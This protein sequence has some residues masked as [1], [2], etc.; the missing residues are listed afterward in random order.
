MHSPSNSIWSVNI[1]LNK[2]HIKL[3]LFNLVIFINNEK[4]KLTTTRLPALATIVSYT[5]HVLVLQKWR[6]NSSI[7]PTSP[8]ATI[9]VFIYFVAFLCFFVFFLCLVVFLYF[10]VFLCFIV[11][12]CRNLLFTITL[13]KIINIDVKGISKEKNDFNWIIF[14]QQKNERKGYFQL[15]ILPF[16]ASFFALVL[17]Y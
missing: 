3:L 13:R 11:F 2:W 10:L 7:Q 8:S 5:I 1:T 17:F 12:L 4:K 6:L 16:F 15:G 14:L 9:V